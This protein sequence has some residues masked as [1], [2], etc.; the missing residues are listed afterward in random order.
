VPTPYYDHEN[1]SYVMIPV[2]NLVRTYFTGVSNAYCLVF[3]ACCREVKKLSKF[4]I[5]KLVK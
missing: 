1:K 2:E 5:E 4:E 3:F